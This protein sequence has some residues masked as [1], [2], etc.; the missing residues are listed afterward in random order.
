MT[1]K[2][3]KLLWLG[4]A[5]VIGSYIVKYAVTGYLNW[6]YARQQEAQQA[7][8]QKQK[9]AP[10]PLAEAAKAMGN[11]SGDWRGHA[12]MP[13]RGLCN[14]GLRLEQ[15]ELGHYTA[16]SRFACLHEFKSPLDQ[17]AKGPLA[18]TEPDATI[19]T[20]TVKDGAIHLFADKTAD[21]D[22]CPM[23]NMQITPFGPRSLLAEWGDDRECYE[24]AQAVQALAGTAPVAYQSGKYAK[25][26]KRYACVKPLRNALYTFAWQTTLTESWALDYYQRKRAEGKS[27][28]MA[29]RALANV[30]VRIIF[31]MWFN[32]TLYEAATFEKAQQVHAQR[33]A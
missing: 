20:G 6:V 16:Y 4:L 15:K 13:N 21:V 7:T 27:H 32:R 33:A 26:H 23:L 2:N 30:W 10:D 3:K 12:Y 28:S 19:L 1:T 18:Q 25:A 8:K 24:S 5:I 9:A 22:N 29:V 11:L 14:M 17:I 31:A